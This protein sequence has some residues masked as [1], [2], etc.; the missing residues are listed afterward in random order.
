MKKII[1]T[2]EQLQEYITKLNNYNLKEPIIIEVEKL[3]KN[4]TNSQLRSFWMLIRICKLFMNSKGNNFTDEEVATYFKIKAGHYIEQDNIKLPKSIANNSNTTKQDI[5]NI[6]NVILEFGI[7]NNIEDC[8]I[9][10]YD[11][12][13]LLTNYKD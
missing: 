1:R 5:T 10:S 2:Q 6:I 12:Q 9:D 8:Y 3:Y 13:S 7:D 4:K 11:L